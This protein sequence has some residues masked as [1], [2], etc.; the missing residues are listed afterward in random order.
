MPVGDFDLLPNALEL[1]MAVTG[2]SDCIGYKQMHFIY[3]NIK[4]RLNEWRPSVG[5][6]ERF[7][8][9][10]EEMCETACN[11]YEKWREEHI[12][13]F[14]EKPEEQNCWQDGHFNP[15]DYVRE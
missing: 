3:Q 4:R 6:W 14:G 1:H 13:M 9:A 11:E 7:D 5:P 15:E 8:N 2:A 12:E 10:V